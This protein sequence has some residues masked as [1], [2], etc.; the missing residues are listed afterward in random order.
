MV[1]R[2]GPHARANL[3]QIELCTTILYVH[4]H[5]KMRS[6]NWPSFV[7]Q[8]HFFCHGMSIMD[9]VVLLEISIKLPVEEVV[10]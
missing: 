8:A 2:A 6:P 4:V 3:L 1:D 7:L 5:V 10:L 9:G